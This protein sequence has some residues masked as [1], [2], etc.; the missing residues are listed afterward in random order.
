MIVEVVK[1]QFKLVERTTEWS[2]HFYSFIRIKSLSYSKWSN[3][4]RLI[5]YTND[6]QIFKK[7]SVTIFNYVF[8]FQDQLELKPTHLHPTKTGCSWITH[9]NVSRVWLN[10]AR[11]SHGN[12][13]AGESVMSVSMSRQIRYETVTST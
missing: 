2:M 7:Y 4:C 3:L 12:M 5:L 10:E 8:S 9:L 1:I 11:S 6:F 13:G